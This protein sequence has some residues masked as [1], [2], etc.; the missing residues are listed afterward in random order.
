MYEEKLNDL[1]SIESIEKIHVLNE[2]YF[3]EDREWPA[4]PLR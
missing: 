2:L 1:S 3:A 4:K